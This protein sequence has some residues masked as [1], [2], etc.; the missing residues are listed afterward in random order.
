MDTQTTVLASRQSGRSSESSSLDAVEKQKLANK[1]LP[2]TR[3]DLHN[4]ASPKRWKT[5]W[6]AFRY[7][8]NLTPKQVD[9]F[10]ASY[11]IYNLDWS[12]EK[13]M[14]ETLG[15][16]YQAKVGDCLK[17]Y[18]GVLN[19]LCA[20][21]DVEK[22]YIPPFMSKKAT[23]LENQLLYE[24]SIAQ[25]IGLSAGDHVLDLGCGRGRVAAHMTQY[26]GAK[27][28]GL[29]IDPN[30]IG[31][32]KTYNEKLGFT[33]NS[34]VV[35][36]FNSLPLPFEDASFDAFY[37]IQALSLCKDLPSLFRE[38]YR[39]VK[40]GAKISLLDWVS[41]PDYDPSNPEHAELMRRVK[42]LIGAVGT[43]TPESLEKA[44]TDAGFSVV[45]S[46]NASVGGLQAP[47]IDKVDFYFRSMRQ[48]ILGL[49]KT[50]VLPRHF[51]TLINRLCLD[52]EAFIKMDTMRLVT[53][54][55][56]I[57]AQKPPQ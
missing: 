49:V 38:I 16:D 8:N 37:Q 11:V 15:P 18:Y 19:H 22:M 50:H 26:S 20:L 7:L 46:D 52:G 51:K 31:Q 45:R 41:L 27:V 40:P 56:R 21:G 9:D 29:N 3:P 10:M 34:F 14:I 32:A 44:L 25:D 54:S 28:T 57:I 47:L 39:V 23:V 17:A 55:Y 12:D 53:T 43:P 36:D 13:A 30:Q 2:Q 5:F 48:V 42:P 1:E 6:K 35:Q 33:N 24:E 4:S